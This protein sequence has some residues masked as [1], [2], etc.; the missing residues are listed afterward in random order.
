MNFPHHPELRPFRFCVP[1]MTV[2]T[3]RGL[4]PQRLCEKPTI[5]IPFQC[6]IG[7]LLTG[8][9]WLEIRYL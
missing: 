6:L 5:P 9:M 7:I 2:M 4:N 8:T 1:N 3:L